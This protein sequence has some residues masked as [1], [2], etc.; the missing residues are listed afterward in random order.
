[1]NRDAVTL[2]LLGSLIV[3]AGVALLTRSGAA[4]LIA[5]GLMMVS[6]VRWIERSG[7]P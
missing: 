4:V 1:M 3:L 5:T 7:K 2:H 6:F